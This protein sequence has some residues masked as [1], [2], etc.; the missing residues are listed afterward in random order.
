MMNSAKPARLT[1]PSTERI[2]KQTAD[3]QRDAASRCRS[4]AYGEARVADDAIGPQYHLLICRVAASQYSLIRAGF[5]AATRLLWMGVALSYGCGGYARLATG[6][7]PIC[8]TRIPFCKNECEQFYSF[9]KNDKPRPRADTAYTW[10]RGLF[11]YPSAPDDLTG[12][13]QHLSLSWHCKNNTLFY[14]SHFFHI[15]YYVSK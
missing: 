5:D 11:F 10:I 12:I 6:Y 4:L 15:Y 9:M 3:G 7:A 13:R 2:S 1:S 14:D 8:A